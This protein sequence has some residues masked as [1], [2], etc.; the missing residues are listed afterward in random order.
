[1][2]ID[3]LR[4]NM[5]IE[6]NENE[7]IDTESPE[8]ESVSENEMSS[9]SVDEAQAAP[10]EPAGPKSAQKSWAEIRKE[11][12]ERDAYAKQVERERD[13]ARNLLKRIEEAYQNEQR[14]KQ[15][16]QPEEDIDID[17]IADDDY[18]PAEKFKKFVKQEKRRRE[19]LEENQKLQSQ[20]TEEM[21]ME[22]SLQE[23]HD[24]WNLVFNKQNIAKLA[25]MD[26]DLA[27]TIYNSTDSLKKKSK[28]TYNAI[29]RYGIY[30]PKANEEKAIARLNTLKPKSPNS[31][32]GVTSTNPLA[33]ASAFTGRMSA[34][35][36]AR[37]WEHAQ[38]LA[39]SVD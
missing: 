36:K 20:V 3:Y 33:H 4:N 5:N 38:R 13:E 29:K 15:Q 2:I 19:Q 9:V 34:E 26:P 37:Q 35:D 6:N 1:M 14:S 12:D 28:S 23:E 7:L 32:G 8:I 30:S 27:S 11:R 24:D 16:A 39:R 18:V 17:S 31:V 22:K 10:D 21:K 25:E